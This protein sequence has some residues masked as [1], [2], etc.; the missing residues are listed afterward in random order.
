MLINGEQLQ[1]NDNEVYSKINRQCHCRKKK[2]CSDKEAESGADRYMKLLGA[3]GCREFLIK[4]M[5][6]LP[7]E[8]REHILEL[9]LRPSV[10]RRPQYFTYVAKRELVKSGVN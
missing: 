5:Y 2:L 4:V 9:A 7:Y 1:I 6:Y 8:T 3:T 10:K